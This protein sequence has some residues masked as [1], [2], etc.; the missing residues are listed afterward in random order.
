MGAPCRFCRH[1]VAPAGYVRRVGIFEFASRVSALTQP[2]GDTT[3]IR[4]PFTG[5]TAG[6]L[7]AIVW[8]DILD[9]AAAGPVTRAEA[10]TVPAVMKARQI[11]VGQIARL[12]LIALDG[13][14]EADEPWLQRTGGTLSPWHRMAWTVDDLLFGGWSL[15]AVDRA[16]DA[17]ILD[18]VRVPAEWWHFESDGT[19]V[20]NRDGR[21]EP[22]GDDEVI[23]I[24][25]PAEGLCEYAARTIRAARNIE[26]SWAT[27]V[28]SPIPVME[29]HHTVDEQL[30]DTEVDSLIMDYVTARNDPN[31]AV[32]YSPF[33]IELKPHGDVVADV[34]IEARNA[35]RLD[36]ANMTGLPA[37]ALDGSLS[38]ASLTYSTIEGA[39]TDIAE[40]LSLWVDPIAARLSQDDVV[41]PGRRVR[42]DTGD[43]DTAAP[44][45]TGAPMED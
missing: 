23:L 16:D 42:F 14:V 18:A 11:L 4:S 13:D 20:V 25:G 30:T 35:I 27:R 24:P 6:E 34:M 1:G 8:S 32:V 9:G 21:Y 12:P 39:R 31:G 7:S 33:D 45:P 3:T 43:R 38:T 37:A 17:R 36:V 41:K 19:V 40:A 5:T 22:P 10:V 29:L 2:T 26:T 15:W 44:S 28:K